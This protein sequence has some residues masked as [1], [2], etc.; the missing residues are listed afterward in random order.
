VDTEI[1][2]QE[3]RLAAGKRIGWLTLAGE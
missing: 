3:N 1:A 2:E